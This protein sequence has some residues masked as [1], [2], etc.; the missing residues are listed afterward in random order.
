VTRVTTEQLLRH[1]ARQSAGSSAIGLVPVRRVQLLVVLLAI[2]SGSGLLLDIYDDETAF[3]RNAYQGADLVSVLL[4]VPL[5]LLALRFTRRGSVRGVL[6]LLGGLGYVAYQYGYTFAYGWSRLFPVHLTL[7]ALSAYTLAEMLIRLDPGAIADSL[8]QRARVV[9]VARFL[10]VIG[11]GL[12]LMEG[13]QVV[14]ALV[15]GDPPPIVART[16]HP[17]SPVYILDLGLVV[18]LMLLASRWLGRRRPWGL[19]AASVLLVKGITVGLG[20]L[21]ANAFALLSETTTD[22]P[23]NIMWVVIAAGSA[24]ALVLLL[25]QTRPASSTDA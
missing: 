15:T 25:R 5:L 24:W 10:F 13:V 18:P 3:A 22:G 2:A 20:L 14:V 8:D 11:L 23:L 1:P 12:G 16:G 7:L 17:T 4:A 19:V 6:L 21:A 9:G